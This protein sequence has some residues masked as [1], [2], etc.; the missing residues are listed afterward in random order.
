MAAAHNNIKLIEYFLKEPKYK[1]LFDAKD[2]ETKKTK[3][4]PLHY[5]AKMGHKDTI[6]ILVEKCMANKEAKD[7]MNRTPLYI[8][9]EYGWYH[10]RRSFV[11]AALIVF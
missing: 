4:T 10:R 9:A 1:K 5:A 7:F 6:K 8:A 2:N 3:Q 11:A